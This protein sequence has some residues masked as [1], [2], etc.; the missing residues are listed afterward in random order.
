M[1]DTV[2]AILNR[3][4]GPQLRSCLD[5]LL[6]QNLN[7]TVIVVVDGNS[8]DDS[9]RILEE[10]AKDDRRVQFFMQK[11]RG[12]GR[13]RN[14]LIQYVET[15]FP[16]AKRI[17]WGDAENI[18]HRNYLSSITTI[19]AD[20]V[21]GVNIID[22]DS[23][24]GQS[25]WWYY[26]GFW[27]KTVVGNN[28]SVKMNLYKKYHYEPITRTEDFFFRKQLEKDKARFAKDSNA[29]CY[30]KTVESLS[31]LIHWEK[32]RTLGLLEGAK[33][34]GRVPSL[35]APYLGLVS[36]ILLYFMLLPFVFLT[37]P[38]LAALYISILVVIPSYI[39]IRGRRYIKQPLKL[40][41]LFFIPVFILDPFT[42]LFFLLRG[43]IRRQANQPNKKEFAKA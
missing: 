15:R 31:E 12:T 36:A 11:T 32:S 23:P 22:S 18:Y 41:V 38:L 43:I 1:V 10:Y 34:T 7:G 25:L 16:E 28:E 14:E 2:V 4:H 26:N 27:G 17:V 24:L 33:L 37:N 9:L 21:G 35:L 5:S 3:N 30:I 8:T 6:K 20:I 40:T 19:D 29:V 42:V 13:A 39:W